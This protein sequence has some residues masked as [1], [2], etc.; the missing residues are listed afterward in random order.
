M[1]SFVVDFGREP[2][3]FGVLRASVRVPP[4]ACA[5]SA[6]ACGVR[7]GHFGEVGG[8]RGSALPCPCRRPGRSV[9]DCVWPAAASHDQCAVSFPLG[10][11]PLPVF[12]GSCW[13]C[14]RLSLL[15]VPGARMVW[16]HDRPSSVWPDVKVSPPARPGPSV[17]CALRG[18]Q[19]WASSEPGGP[20]APS[21]AMTLRQAGRPSSQGGLRRHL[22]NFSLSPDFVFFL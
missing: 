14:A 10:A 12:W 5:A 15:P 18:K 7:E 6:A 4:R 16:S 22:A 9:S 21:P 2:S 17:P 11:G 8:W 3:A 19:W 13:V 1:V 20:S